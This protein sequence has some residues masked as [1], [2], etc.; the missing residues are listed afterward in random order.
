MYFIVQLPDL[1]RTHD[2]IG[3]IKKQLEL[4]TV[5]FSYF[6]DKLMLFRYIPDD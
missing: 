2:Q 3:L 5:N 1:K 6:Y 4:S